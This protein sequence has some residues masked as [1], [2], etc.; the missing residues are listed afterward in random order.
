MP[1]NCFS[2]YFIGSIKLINENW[3]F[4]IWW[5]TKHL[6]ITS[7][8]AQQCCDQHSW[9]L[10]AIDLCKRGANRAVDVYHLNI[11][12]LITKNEQTFFTIAR[13][14]WLGRT[15]IVEMNFF[16]MI[17]F[18]RQYNLQYLLNLFFWTHLLRC[19]KLKTICSIIYLKGTLSHSFRFGC[20]IESIRGVS[21]Y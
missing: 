21:W 10:F 1:L 19:S 18:V 3:M 9:T 15:S 17:R 14:K 12:L 6:T 20:F 5:P 8:S 2:L 7:K 13:F 11:Q 4:L 16:S